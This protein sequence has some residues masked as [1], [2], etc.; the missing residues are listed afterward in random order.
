MPRNKLAG[1]GA[2]NSYKKLSPEARKNK[3]EYDKKFQKK[4]IQVKRRVEANK[5]NRKAGTYGNND[6]KDASHTKSGKI[7]MAS[8]KVNRAANGKGSRSRHHA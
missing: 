3:L 7:V 6:G 1:T 2:K 8:Q 5:A 4:P